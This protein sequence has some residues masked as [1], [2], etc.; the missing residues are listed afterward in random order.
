MPNVIGPSTIVMKS[1]MEMPNA[2]MAP[3]KYPMV[4]PQEREIFVV[5]FSIIDPLESQ[6]S[7]G[8]GQMKFR[9]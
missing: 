4:A 6:M 3:I 7:P 8:E 9:D 1:R 5:V 2:T